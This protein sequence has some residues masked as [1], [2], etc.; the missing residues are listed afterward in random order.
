MNVREITQDATETLSHYAAVSIAFTVLTAWLV[1]AFQAHSPVHEV[2]CGF[3]RRLS[4][5]VLY[6]GRWAGVGVGSPGGVRGWVRGRSGL[7]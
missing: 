5:P 6:V 4:W 7:P 2:G 1:V 3:W